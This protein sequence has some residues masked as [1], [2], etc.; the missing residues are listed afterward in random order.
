M[1]PWWGR[2]WPCLARVP[3]GSPQ[4]AP[5]HL[6]RHAR[7]RCL[8]DWWTLARERALPSWA[9]QP[10]AGH[11]GVRSPPP[12]L[13]AIDATLGVNPHLHPVAALAQPGGC[14]AELVRPPWKEP[15]RREA[16][17]P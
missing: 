1:Q 8:V 4:S 15:P 14:W 3:P 16:P 17:P 5:R 11:L 2:G 6:Q 10:K 9:K 12:P 13:P 7:P